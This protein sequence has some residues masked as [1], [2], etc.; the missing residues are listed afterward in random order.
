MGRFNDWD[1]FFKFDDQFLVF[2]L[3]SSYLET[4]RRR[5]VDIFRAGLWYQGF[6]RLISG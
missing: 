4:V 3:G 2:G 6:E 1:E 5:G